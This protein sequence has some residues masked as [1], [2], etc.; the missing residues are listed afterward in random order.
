[1]LYDEDAGNV[2][3]FAKQE[4]DIEV[5]NKIPHLQSMCHKI[6]KKSHWRNPRKSSL[7]VRS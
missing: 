2:R 6:G 1:M 4:K 7:L 5:V 3:S